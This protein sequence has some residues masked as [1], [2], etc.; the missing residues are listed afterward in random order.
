MLNFSKY[1]ISIFFLMP[2]IGD[3]QPTDPI[4]TILKMAKQPK[5][6]LFEISEHKQSDIMW[7]VDTINNGSKRLRK[8]FPNLKIVVISH[9]EEMFALT[10]TRK[11]QFPKVHSLMQLMDEQNISLQV[12]ATQAGWQHKTQSDFPDFIQLVESAPEQIQFYEDLGYILI[13]VTQPSVKP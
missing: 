10:K 13:E 5:G 8:R 7:A 6:V 9:G 12:C 11:K 4:D 2:L 1:F 3:A